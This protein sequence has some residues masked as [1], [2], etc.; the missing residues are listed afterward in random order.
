VSQENSL[1]TWLSGGSL[2]GGTSGDIAD[3]LPP[4]VHRWHLPG[5]A[6]SVGTPTVGA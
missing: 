6:L 3:H 4:V 5:Q 1:C 2:C